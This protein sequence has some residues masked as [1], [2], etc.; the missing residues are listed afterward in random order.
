MNEKLLKFLHSLSCSVINPVQKSLTDN[1]VVG[2]YCKSTS[3]MKVGIHCEK[4]EN[5]ITENGIDYYLSGP[6]GSS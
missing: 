3:V 4:I 6:S 1:T 2:W 5:F